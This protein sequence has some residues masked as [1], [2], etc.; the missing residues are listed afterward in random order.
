MRLAGCRADMPVRLQIALVLLPVTWGVSAGVLV[1]APLSIAPARL[2]D[3]AIVAL[4]AGLAAAAAV[5]AAWTLAGRLAR[6]RAR[7][8]LR[9]IAGG[10]GLPVPGLERS[11]AGRVAPGQPASRKGW[12]R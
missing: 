1:A 10:K 9:V 3:L 5:A 8:R 4:L 2:T 12:I 11:P 6:P 7:P